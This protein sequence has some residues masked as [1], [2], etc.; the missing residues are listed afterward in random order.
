M[1]PFWVST[2]VLFVLSRLES[3][4]NHANPR[5]PANQ[6]S[7]L[8]PRG[9]TRCAL[10]GQPDSTQAFPVHSASLAA[11]ACPSPAV[12][13]SS[14]ALVSPPASVASGDHLAPARFF[15]PPKILFSSFAT[16]PKKPATL[17]TRY[18]IRPSYH[19]PKH[20]SSLGTTS[21]ISKKLSIHLSFS[22]V[23]FLIY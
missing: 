12:A 20:H 16:L 23:L 1:Q 15:S 10:I 13:L 17:Q 14:L 18:S 7:V 2:R 4:R 8:H 19:P 11:S 9:L 3:Y 22:V 6:R 21:S 5:E